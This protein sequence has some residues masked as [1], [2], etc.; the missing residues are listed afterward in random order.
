M[1][2]SDWLVVLQLVEVVEV[3]E[4]VLVLIATRLIR[5]LPSVFCELCTSIKKLHRNLSKI[6]DIREYETHKNIICYRL[7]P[8]ASGLMINNTYLKFNIKKEV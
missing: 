3:V 7:I 1:I 6:L 8:C 5:V 4:V 2:G